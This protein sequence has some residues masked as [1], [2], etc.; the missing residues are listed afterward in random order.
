MIRVAILRKE[1]GIDILNKEEI[2]WASQAELRH[3]IDDSL[4]CA[5]STPWDSKTQNS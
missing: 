5:A 3:S 4:M 2:F 1:D